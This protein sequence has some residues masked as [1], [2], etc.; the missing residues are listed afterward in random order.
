[1]PV[2]DDVPPSSFLDEISALYELNMF[3]GYY[4]SVL[5]LIIQYTK[6]TMNVSTHIESRTHQQLLQHFA[7]N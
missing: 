5:S 7:S 2:A 1:M 6:S 4:H 3:G